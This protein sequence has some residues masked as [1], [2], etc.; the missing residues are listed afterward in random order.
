MESHS[1]WSWAPLVFMICDYPTPMNGHGKRLREP[2]QC[3][4][5][6]PAT[7]AFFFRSNDVSVEHDGASTF[8][9]NT[10]RTRMTES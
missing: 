1:A 8:S 9:R 3:S 2:R 4:A 6:A 10:G 5:R 7:V